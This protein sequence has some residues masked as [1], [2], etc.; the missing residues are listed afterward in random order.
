MQDDDTNS[1]DIAM[2]PSVRQISRFDPD[3]SPVDTTGVGVLSPFSGYLWQ[4]HVGGVSDDSPPLEY[5]RL[6]PLVV[7]QLQ[8]RETS[9]TASSEIQQPIQ[10]G[11]ND[12]SGDEG[13]DSPAE[14]L[15][16]REAIERE[17]ETDDTETSAA[18]SD[19][20][21][22]V[23]PPRTHERMVVETQQGDQS[24]SVNTQPDSEPTTRPGELTGESLGQ[25][26]THRATETA[27]E[28]SRDRPGNKD[29]VE[30]SPPWSVVD[31]APTG[32]ENESPAGAGISDVDDQGTSRR[33]DRRSTTADPPLIV[34][35][36][37]PV[38]DD[39][40]TSQTRDRHSDTSARK[41][42]ETTR[43]VP[44]NASQQS[45]DSTDLGHQDEQAEDRQP[46]V[47]FE[48]MPQQTRDR[49]VE[50]LSDELARQERIERERRGL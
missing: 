6:R 42:A 30:E 23:E 24:S 47:D 38:L 5:L 49:F 28:R 29:G 27:A 7:Q 15:T 10:T 4:R 36:P 48:R 20:R 17:A 46:A 22:S 35:S 32:G 1:D 13:S 14:S 3:G 37:D 21:P 34:Q 50:Q 26:L 2:N 39:T 12:G 9:D 41:A 44:P 8:Q 45:T 18:V 31:N 33:S 19:Y 43:S 40:Q 11:A 16:V 25:D